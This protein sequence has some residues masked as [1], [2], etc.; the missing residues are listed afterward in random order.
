M[1]KASG[2]LN[3]WALEAEQPRRLAFAQLWTKYMAC[4]LLA[5]ISSLDK[6]FESTLLGFRRRF[7]F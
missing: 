7:R 3:P 4:S 6:A 5:H 1:Q 2:S